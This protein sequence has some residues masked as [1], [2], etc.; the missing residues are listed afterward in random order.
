M[1]LSAGAKTNPKKPETP[2]E[3]EMEEG[4]VRVIDGESYIL[5]DSSFKFRYDQDQQINWRNIS[6][7]SFNQT[8]KPT[9][10]EDPSR[11]ILVNLD[12]LAYTDLNKER[13]TRFISAEGRQAAK[14]LQCGMQYYMFT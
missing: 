11:D 2:I 5:S 12:A 1:S 8:G 10:T 6:S 4:E 13:N 7:M 3:A 14:V 9:W